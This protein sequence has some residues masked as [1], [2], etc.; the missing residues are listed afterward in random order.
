M[1]STI[2]TL[3]AVVALAFIAT[4]FSASKDKPHGHNG[5]L[6]PFDGKH[7]PYSVDSEQLKKLSA[8]Q[9]VKSV[10]DVNNGNAEHY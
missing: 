6:P 4:V 7:L 5:V 8:G 3:V 1:S 10:I 2:T 9:P